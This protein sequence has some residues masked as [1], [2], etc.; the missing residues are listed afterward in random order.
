LG[1]FDPCTSDLAGFIILC[2]DIKAVDGLSI[3]YQKPTWLCVS[4][5]KIRELRWVTCLR[6]F[7]RPGDVGFSRNGGF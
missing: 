7:P 5:L 2:G 6:A 4:S 3:R 1:F